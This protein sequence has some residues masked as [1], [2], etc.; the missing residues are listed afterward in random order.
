MNQLTFNGSATATSLAKGVKV[1]PGIQPETKAKRL[2][3]PSLNSNSTCADVR[4]ALQAIHRN[5]GSSQDDWHFCDTP[6]GFNTRKE[7]VNWVG[8]Q[9][10]PENRLDLNNLTIYKDFL[11]GR[12]FQ[13]HSTTQYHIGFFLTPTRTWVT[14]A[15][16]DAVR[17]P[18]HAWAAVL[19]KL[20]KGSVGRFDL[21]IWDS[22]WDHDKIKHPFGIGAQRAL[23]NACKQSDRSLAAVWRGGGGNTER[24]RCMQLTLDFIHRIAQG[25]KVGNFP[26]WDRMEEAR[27]ERQTHDGKTRFTW[28]TRRLKEEGDEW[29]GGR[30]R[31]GGRKGKAA[32]VAHV[33]EVDLGSEDKTGKRDG[34]NASDGGSEGSSRSLWLGGSRAPP[35]SSKRRATRSISRSPFRSTQ[36]SRAASPAQSQTSRRA[37]KVA[38]RTTIASAQRAGKTEGEVKEA[39]SSR[40]LDEAGAAET[41]SITNSVAVEKAVRAEGFA[42]DA[43]IKKTRE[44]ECTREEMT[45][46]PKLYF[47]L[48]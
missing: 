9:R 22:N 27:Y 19:R 25:G 33:A 12:R 14:M 5:Y 37:T 44:P 8:G 3:V 34:L 1:T 36:V 26:Q 4:A 11:K 23:I 16:A 39:G 47:I 13:V 10:D 32:H 41:E 43:A 7:K 24:G 35:V 40:G 46:N 29:A 17:M 45:T 6:I 18:W 30:K 21:T 2:R 48:T 15:G 42:G 20:P 31:G 38:H 28:E